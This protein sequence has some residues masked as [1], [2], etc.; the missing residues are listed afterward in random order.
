MSNPRKGTIMTCSRPDCEKTY[1]YRSSRKSTLCK[2]HAWVEACADPT[3]KAKRRERLAEI[4]ATTDLRARQSQ[5]RKEYLRRKM[6]EDPAFAE[7]QRENGRRLVTLGNMP[8]PED[9]KRAGRSI[10]KTRL[11][12]I[13]LEYRDDYLALGRKTKMTAAER[14]D[15]ILEQAASDAAYY[16]RTGKMRLSERRK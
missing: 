6:A 8:S 1:P 15:V 3:R 7:K 2:N 4:Y 5:T 14:T 10:S 12:H 9:R 11:A 16:N 13:P